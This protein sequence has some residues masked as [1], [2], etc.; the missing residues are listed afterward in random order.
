MSLLGVF[1]GFFAHYSGVLQY[2]FTI[3]AQRVV[4]SSFI[5]VQK[6]RSV[7]RLLTA[8]CHLL[9]VSRPDLEIFWKIFKK[10]FFSPKVSKMTLVDSKTHFSHFLKI[11]AIHFLLRNPGLRNFLKIFKKNFFPKMPKN[12][13]G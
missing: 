7:K 2:F 11:P 5:A 12:H 6:I 1:R 4:I 9:P 13:F 10:K 3:F 8:W